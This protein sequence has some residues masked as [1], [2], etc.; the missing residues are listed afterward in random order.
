[1]GGKKLLYVRV[2]ILGAAR[3]GEARQLKEKAR[4]SRVKSFRDMLNLL[5]KIG[6]V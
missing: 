6:F 5:A 1:V 2:K 3:A 4:A